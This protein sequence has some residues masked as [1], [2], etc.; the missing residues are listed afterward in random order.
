MNFIPDAHSRSM[1][2][3]N[4][5][6]HPT[7]NSSYPQLSSAHIHPAARPTDPHLYHSVD[8][9]LHACGPLAKKSFRPRCDPVPFHKNSRPIVRM[10]TWNLEKCGAEKAENPGVK[11]VVAMTLLENG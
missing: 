7:D 10:A 9:M 5:Y 8:D 1:S 3:T 6:H 2:Y 11:E 4:G